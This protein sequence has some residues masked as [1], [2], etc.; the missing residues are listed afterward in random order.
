MLPHHQLIR[1]RETASG[2]AKKLST[3]SCSLAKSD[4]LLSPAAGFFNRFSAKRV[5]NTSWHH[6]AESG[7]NERYS[8]T[9]VFRHNVRRPEVDQLIVPTVNTLADVHTAEKNINSL[10]KLGQLGEWVQ[11]SGG[12]SDADNLYKWS[13]GVPDKTFY[14]PFCLQELEMLS[15]NINNFKVMPAVLG[16]SEQAL[17][18]GGG[19]GSIDGVPAA[20]QAA[21]NVDQFGTSLQANTGAVRTV[22]IGDVDPNNILME[23][24]IATSAEAQGA[25]LT[26]S[27]KMFTNYPYKAIQTT[28]SG[29]CP[30]L[31]TDMGS[32]F[33]QL[34]ARINAIDSKEDYGRYKAQLG[35]SIATFTFVNTGDSAMIV[36]MVVHRAK[37]NTQVYRLAPTLYNSLRNFNSTGTEYL[38]D[39]HSNIVE[40]YGKNYLD[41]H[42]RNEDRLMTTYQRAATDVD[43]DPKVKFLPTSY[44][45]PVRAQQKTTKFFETNATQYLGDMQKDQPDTPGFVDI[46]REHVI[47]PPNCR[48]TISITMPAKQYD[49]ATLNYNCVLNELGYAVTFGVTGKTTR[50]VLPAKMDEDKGVLGARFMGRQAAATSFHIYGHEHQ[51]VY[52]CALVEKADYE[53]NNARLPPLSDPHGL[54]ADAV[55]RDVGDRDGSASRYEIKSTDAQS[56]GTAAST[57]IQV[58][59]KRKYEIT[60]QNEANK[61]S[62]L[63]WA[64][65]IYNMFQDFSWTNT[66]ALLDAKVAEVCNEVKS[67]IDFLN[68]HIDNITYAEQVIRLLISYVN[69]AA[70]QAAGA[71]NFITEPAANESLIASTGKITLDS[72]DAFMCQRTTQAQPAKTIQEVLDLTPKHDELRRLDELPVVHIIGD[73]GITGLT[74]R[75]EGVIEKAFGLTLLLKPDVDQIF[76]QDLFNFVDEEGDE[77]LSLPDHGGML[78][79]LTPQGGWV[80]G[81]HWDYAQEVVSGSTGSVPTVT[82]LGGTANCTVNLA[83]G[84]S[85]TIPFGRLWNAPGAG[86]GPFFVDGASSIAWTEAAVNTYLTAAYSNSDDAIIVEGYLNGW[87]GGSSTAPH[88]FNLLRGVHWSVSF[89]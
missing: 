75:D 19:Y 50:Q 30:N 89:A 70:V 25:A 26:T 85:T 78:Y 31:D 84:N 35:V 60:Q 77:I 87:N 44:R 59:K 27:F 28:A 74:N 47:V 55:Y 67:S 1:V 21:L 12:Y 48:K 68:Q 46:K 11:D 10:Q 71:S 22:N 17:P 57:Q 88:R 69:A 34:N 18:G 7:Q 5:R 81:V 20:V 32:V 29:G 54:L 63:G 65:D 8:F 62:A 86:G 52:P 76:S 79:N 23:D 2:D 6:S 37:E 56:R 45:T 61:K 72:I 41:Y 43:K 38:K 73:A 3:T 58:S 24:H 39:L 36:D 66:M 82:V 40:T 4:A 80:R 33:R 51:V 53:S 15:W 16:Y 9:Y 14:S 42:Q 64:I 49:P 83:N 13:Q